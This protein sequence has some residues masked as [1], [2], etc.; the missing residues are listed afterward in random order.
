M[1]AF[2]CL[3]SVGLAAFLVF[4]SLGLSAGPAASQQIGGITGS[5]EDAQTGL[6][7]PSVQVFIS[8][9][10]LETISQASGAYLLLN[11]PSG[12]Y[13]LTAARLGYR[14]T[15]QE[16]MVGAG[17]PRVVDFSLDPE[18]LALDEIIVTGTAGGT[19]RRAVGNVVGSVDMAS[20]Q[21]LAPVL[22]VYEALSTRVPGLLSVPVGGHPGGEGSRINIRGVT[23]V[24]LGDQPLIIV[25]GVRINAE[26]RDSRRVATGRLNDI[27]PEEIES[28]EV[29]KGP[30]AA[31]LY[32]TEASAG[33]IQIITKR[34]VEGAPVFDVSIE[35]GARWLGDPNGKMPINYGRLEDEFGVEGP[36]LQMNILDAEAARGNRTLFEYGNIKKASINVRGGTSTIRYMASLNRAD[37][38]GVVSF[39]FDQKT[40]GRLNLDVTPNDRI[41]IRAGLSVM[42]GLTQLPGDIWGYGLRGGPRTA[43]DFGGIESCLN[44]WAFCEGP[45]RE[46]DHHEDL[47]DVSRYMANTSIQLDLGRFFQHRLTVGVDQSNELQVDT[48]L[49]DVDE[50]FGGSRGAGRRDIDERE[51]VSKTFDY[52]VSQQLQA[53]E[54]IGLTTSGGFQYYTKRIWDRGI[55]GRVFATRALSTISSAGT[56]EAS[57]SIVENTTVGFYVQEQVDWQERIFLTVAMRFDENSAFGVDFGVQ[58]YPK[59]S[60]T[61]VVSEESFWNVDFL[62]P[63]RVRGAW[64][65]AGR[66][67]DA[68]AA[69]RLYESVPGTDNAPVFTPSSFGNPLL[70][71][72]K[73]EELEVGFDASFFDGRANLEVTRYWKSTF[74]LITDRASLPSKGFPGRRFENVGQVDNWGTEI[75][76]DVRLLDNTGGW[77]SWD[78][79]TAFAT[80]DNELVSLGGDFDRIA[81]RRSTYQVEGFPLSSLLAFR[82]L[83]ADLDSEG[84]PIN[85]MCDGGTGRGVSSSAPNGLEFGGVAVPC[86]DASRLFYG[87][88]T[89][90]WT[91][92]AMST[93]T[94]FEDFR[95]YAAVEARGGATKHQDS[96]GSRHTAWT[97]SFGVNQ[98]KLERDP[99]LLATMAKDRATLGYFDGGYA[100]LNELGVVWSVPT[101]LAGRL[102]FSRASVNFAMR[103][104]GFLWREHNSHSPL[105]GKASY[106]GNLEPVNGKPDP[107][108]TVGSIRFA[109]QQGTQLPLTTTAILGLRV[110][111]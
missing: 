7:L 106:D 2:K 90:K 92:N 62:N 84:A 74:D 72:E 41:T 13:T 38:D 33:V 39:S 1:W 24:A 79:V 59:V 48:Y 51:F 91:V 85:A 6:A 98:P 26:H 100:N 71:P 78:L 61:W 5:I 9:L 53:T 56:T 55:I 34:G 4:F 63:L 73:G 17:A 58:K 65:Q 8:G 3:R 18:A 15:T 42:D 87:S 110:S 111:F 49:K 102:G 12:T 50:T 108:I 76:L 107:R 69:S 93:W 103:N 14:T 101:S 80:M 22:D 81:I 35:A 31:T 29:I 43:A 105:H 28:I 57:E 25:D 94:L 88:T 19:Q 68:L 44:G 83:S 95:V 37:Q 40:T 96:V 47:Y 52:G 16:V 27:N 77:L 82:V 66:Q 104:I 64:G 46:R 45:Q 109:G 11:V 10:G 30:A 20:A 21:A 23:S 75:Q 89:D 54:S 86:D 97:N 99:V 70:G 36:L 32:G 60:G 67:P